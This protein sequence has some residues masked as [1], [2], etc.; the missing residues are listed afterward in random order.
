MLDAIKES[1]LS[2]DAQGL[3]TGPFGAVIYQG[4]MLIAKGHNQV[5][6]LNDPTA[7]AE[8]Q[9]IRAASKKLNQF[10]LSECVIYSS[11]EPCPMCFSA[12]YW[13][14]IKKVYYGATR[15]DAKAIGFID[16]YIYQELERV[17]KN[18]SLPFE[19]LLRDEANQVMQE[20]FTSPH[21][22]TY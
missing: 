20:W 5:I 3:A 21:R 9:A 12:I 18:R 13:A 19:Q 11:C 14:R 6:E 8:V 15:K 22:E 10:D 1:S 16:D 4:D 17:P 7:H 2:L